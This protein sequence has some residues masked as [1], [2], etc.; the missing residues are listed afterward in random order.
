LPRFLF[1]HLKRLIVVDDVQQPQFGTMLATQPR[2]ARH[3]P[4]GA[5]RK[6]RRC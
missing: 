4:F 2:C 3:R 5:A 1:H 6:I